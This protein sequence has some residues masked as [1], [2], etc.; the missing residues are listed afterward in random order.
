M[1]IGTGEIFTVEK[2]PTV[3]SILVVH[4][5][6]V[7]ARVKRAVVELYGSEIAG[8]TTVIV[9]RGRDDT[10]KLVGARKQ[11]FLDSLFA[12]SVTPATLARVRELMASAN[13][14]ARCH[15]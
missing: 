1:E 2:L 12:Q 13:A 9:I 8:R 4:S 6:E 10:G 7:K 5:A 15:G 11:V 14:R 3:G